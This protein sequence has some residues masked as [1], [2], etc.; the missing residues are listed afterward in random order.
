MSKFVGFSL[1]LAFIF[2]PMLTRAQ[3]RMSF[4]A[5]SFVPPQHWKQDR[6]EDSLL[7]SESAGNKYC[8][9]TIYRSRASSG[10]LSADFDKA[11]HEIA[12]QKLKVNA[13][14]AVEPAD[15][16]G[17]WEAKLGVAT[18]RNSGGPFAVLVTA[19][20]GSGRTMAVSVVLNDDAYLPT[21]AAFLDSLRFASPS[22][23]ASAPQKPDGPPASGS[24]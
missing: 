14:P 20:T 2:M 23:T 17:G 16:N 12:I 13:I 8:R 11:W 5:A 22:P 3:E 21:V 7:I 18:T 10:S 1:A 15:A 4:D 24:P 6:P 19:A 9:I